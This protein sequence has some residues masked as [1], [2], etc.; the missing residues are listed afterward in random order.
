MLEDLPI[1]KGQKQ[2]SFYRWAL[3]VGYIISDHIPVTGILGS[4]EA[5]TQYLL[6]FSVQE[7]EKVGKWW[8]RV[9]CQDILVFEKWLLNILFMLS[10]M[11]L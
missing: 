8:T 1:M 6:I 7:V 10:V 9:L 3:E 5:G 11:F 2:G 4:A